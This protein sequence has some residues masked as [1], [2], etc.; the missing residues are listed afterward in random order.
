MWP[1]EDSC[2][3]RTQQGNL[4]RT[5]LRADSRTAQ[6]IGCPQISG[7]PS[8]PTPQRR[9]SGSGLPRSHATS[10]SVGS[11]RQRRKRPGNA[12]SRLASRRCTAECAGHAAGPDACTAEDRSIDGQ[13][14]HHEEADGLS[15]SLIIVP[16]DPSSTTRPTRA[17]HCDSVATAGLT[18]ALSC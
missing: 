14:E 15:R 7:R 2:C 16:N 1:V 10:G 11:P 8:S 4:I 3:E 6:Y 18:A 9:S 13:L 17:F 5:W 12:A